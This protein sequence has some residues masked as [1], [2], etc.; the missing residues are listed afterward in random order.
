[1]T[2]N[3]FN[4]T[5]NVAQLYCVYHPSYRYDIYT[6]ECNSSVVYFFSNPKDFI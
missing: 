5:L 3:V 4:G 2:Y 1:M 6:D